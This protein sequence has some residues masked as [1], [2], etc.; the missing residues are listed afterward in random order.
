[1]DTIIIGNQDHEPFSHPLYE[2]KMVGARGFKPPCFT[3][4]CPIFQYL[5]I[6]NSVSHP[7]HT[8]KPFRLIR[9]AKE[10]EEIKGES[11]GW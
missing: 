7:F 4:N 10:S 6:Q 5:Q 2:K 1:V 11:R 8:L 9:V 3:P